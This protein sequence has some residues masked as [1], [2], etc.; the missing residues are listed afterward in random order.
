[1]GK[2]N[3]R[4]IEVVTKE[5]E[6]AAGQ[7][8]RVYVPEITGEYA[9][10]DQILSRAREYFLLMVQMHTPKPLY[11]LRDAVFPKYRSAFGAQ[12]RRGKPRTEIQALSCQALVHVVIADEI[13]GVRSLKE[14]RQARKASPALY[15]ASAALID[16]SKQHNLIGKRIEID[17]SADP[18]VIQSARTNAIWPLLV[19]LETI[20]HWH[21]APEGWLRW[22]R[23]GPPH[24]R[25]P[26]Q[27]YKEAP[28]PSGTLPPIQL[29]SFV[30]WRPTTVEELSEVNAWQ[31]E[32]RRLF[33]DVFEKYGFDKHGENAD[34]SAQ[35]TKVA[36]DFREKMKRYPKET[37]IDAP[38]WCAQLETETQFKKRMHD[39]LDQWLKSY[40]AE[41]RESAQSLG[42]VEVPGPRDPEHFEW[43]AKYQIGGTTSKQI[44][45]GCSKRLTPSGVGK[46]IQKVLATI[47]L[48]PR[49]GERG[50]KPSKHPRSR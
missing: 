8:R 24:W 22:A 37:M 45:E 16:W 4:R 25:A 31:E 40:I 23:P 46:A 10:E 17:P 9:E 33:S 38:E 30:P 47:G 26:I 19:A 39:S 50:P 49:T 12:E 14:F 5:A 13:A 7:R 34:R 27:F 44:A 43:A 20:L 1:V 29:K 42:L 6:Q 15:T 48:E 11:A 41:Q 35:V 21:F 2:K 18:K 3:G 32:A 36:D 28:V